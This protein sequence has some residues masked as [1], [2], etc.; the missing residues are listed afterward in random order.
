MEI[1]LKILQNPYFLIVASFFYGSILFGYIFSKIFFKKDIRSFGDGNPGTW[2]AFRVGGAKIG[3]PVLLLDYSKGLIPS[4]VAGKFFK[5]EKAFFVLICIAPILGHAFSPFLKFKGGKAMASSFG[6]WT[7]ITLWEGPT[8]MGL[9][10]LLFGA[11]QDNS[12]IVSVSGFIFLFIYL[13]LKGYGIEVL[14]IFI[15][16]FFVVLVKL[17]KELLIKPK[18]GLRNPFKS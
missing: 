9:T 4:I 1:I 8:L 14:I 11:V 13:L 7:G 18:F 5:D 17:N 3:I 10:T 15:L 6:L 2:N 16:N 12:A